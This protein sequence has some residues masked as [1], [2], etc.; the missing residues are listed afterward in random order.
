MLAELDVW[1]NPPWPISWQRTWHRAR[2]HTLAHG[3]VTGADE[4]VRLPRW[5]ERLLSHQITEFPQLAGEQRQLLAQLGLTPTKVDRFHTWPARRRSVTHGLEAARDC[6][7]HHGPLAVSP[8]TTHD[9]FT[10]GKWLN[11]QRHRQR[12]ATQPTRL[13][14]RLTALGTWWIRPGHWNGSGTPGPPAI[15]STAC[16]KAWC[17]GPADQ[18]RTKPGSGCTS[19]R[20]HSSTYTTNKGS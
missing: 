8:L 16:P 13:G 5:L 4:L 9:R 20:P 2:A 14:R 1:W 19:S 10:L 17:D 7:A 15:I 12:A 11:Q 6:A 3:P 18:T